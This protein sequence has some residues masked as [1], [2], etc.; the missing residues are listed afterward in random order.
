MLLKLLRGA[1]ISR[2]RGMR[3]LSHRYARPLLEVPKAALRAYLERRGLGWREDPSNAVP[4]Y[5][6]NKVRLQLI[7]LMAEVP[8]GGGG[9]PLRGD[10]GGGGSRQ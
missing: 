2:V 10:W 6:R 4:R 3:P 9:L 5:R 8:A 7:P 1:H